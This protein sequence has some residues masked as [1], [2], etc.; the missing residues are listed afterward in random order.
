MGIKDKYEVRPIQKEE[1]YPWLLKK[2]YAKRKCSIVYSFGIYRNKILNGVCTF[3]I[4]PSAPL[5]EHVLNG[6]Y[7]SDILELNRLVVDDNHDKNMLSFFVSKAMKML[8][9]PK[10]IISFADPN[11]GHH[12]YIYQA[13]NWIYTGVGSNT[14]NFF[15]ENGDQIHSKWVKKY[16]DDGFKIRSIEQKPK[17]RYIYFIGDKRT[18][19]KMSRNLKYKR[20]PYPKGDN[21]RYD[22]SY[23]PDVQGVLF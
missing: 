1:T 20:L 6:L 18:V 17:H 16:K 13:T 23:S 9:K 5:V 4:P 12:G 8:R 10:C 21:K 2:H 14:P 7:K 15:L 11:N 19:K 3:G 22:A